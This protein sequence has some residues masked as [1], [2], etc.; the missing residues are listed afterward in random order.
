[1]IR[2]YAKGV[3]DIMHYGHVNFLREARALGDWLTVGVSPDARAAALKRQPMFSEDRRAEVISSIRYVDEVITDGPREITLA[4]MREHGF[5]IYAFGTAT[6]SERQFRLADCRELPASMIV[7]IPYTN[8]IS[9]TQIRQL[10]A[11]Q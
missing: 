7:E 6:E 10:L 11:N 3:F 1:M 9:T 2:I 8:G 4:F 5:H